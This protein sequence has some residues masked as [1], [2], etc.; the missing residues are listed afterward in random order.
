MHDDEGP[1]SDEM[2]DLVAAIFGS[3][4]RRGQVAVLMAARGEP[5]LAQFIQR[6]EISEFVKTFVEMT[7]G[8]G[9]DASEIERSI[10]ELNRAMKAR[11]TRLR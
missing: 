8:D 10:A 3:P 6:P 9:V 1:P 2:A 7:I 11:A 4:E 5:E